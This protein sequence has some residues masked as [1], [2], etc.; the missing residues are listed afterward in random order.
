MSLPAAYLSKKLIQRL[1]IKAGGVLRTI[2]CAAD[3]MLAMPEQHAESCQHWRL[4]AQLLL[5]RAD[6]AAVS[7]QVNLALFLDNR[8]DLKAMP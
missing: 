7:K 3:Y 4:A 5:E 1:P 6:V 2:G 8:L